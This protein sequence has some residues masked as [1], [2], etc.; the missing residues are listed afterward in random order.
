METEY[1]RNGSSPQ[2]QG[3]GWKQLHHAQAGPGLSRAMGSQSVGDEMSQPG[4]PDKEF[5]CLYPEQ[6]GVRAWTNSSIQLRALRVLT[7]SPTSSGTGPPSFV[8]NVGLNMG[9]KSCS[10]KE[11]TAWSTEWNQGLY[12]RQSRVGTPG[13]LPELK[14]QYF[15]NDFY[16]LQSASESQ[17]LNSNNREV[18][19]LGTHKNKSK[20][21]EPQ[22]L[23]CI[24]SWSRFSWTSGSFPYI[25]V[26]Y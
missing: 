1:S 18:S 15:N 9:H 5:M 17:Y 2:G 16:N 26:F 25:Q 19:L 3:W 20:A 23:V 11:D 24:V 22:G 7:S 12:I 14:F 21:E 13:P 8:G 4:G 10:S 6:K